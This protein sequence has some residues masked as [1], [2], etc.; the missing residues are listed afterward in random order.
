MV[1]CDNIATTVDYKTGAVRGFDFSI[2]FGLIVD[3]TDNAN[4]HGLNFADSVDAKLFI[5]DVFN[6]GGSGEFFGDNGFTA[7]FESEKEAGGD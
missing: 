1:V 5:G 7:D 6:L 3:I 4:S 2:A